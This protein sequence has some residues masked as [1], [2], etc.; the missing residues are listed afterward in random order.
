MSIA[1]SVYNSEKDRHIFLETIFRMP[2]ITVRDTRIQTFQYR[3]IHRIVPCNDWLFKLTEK[4]SSTCEYRFHSDSLIYFLINCEKTK[5][6]WDSWVTWW[7]NLTGCNIED[8]EFLI[9]CLLFGFPSNSSNAR[10]INFI[11]LYD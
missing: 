11:T 10:L 9:E 6:F 5:A 3:L 4:P 2:F 7:L 1:K 8:N